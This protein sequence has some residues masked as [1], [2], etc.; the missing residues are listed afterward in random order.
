[1]ICCSFSKLQSL[2]PAAIKVLNLQN[3]L[4]KF[5]LQ[6]GF[7]SEEPLGARIKMGI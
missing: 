4:D 6:D 3:W 2:S 5:Y 7:Y 1:M